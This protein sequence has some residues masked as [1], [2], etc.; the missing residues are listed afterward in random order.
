MRQRRPSRAI[1][2]DRDGTLMHNCHYCR[3]PE[4]VQ[5][6]PGV[7]AALG[8]LSGAG[9][10]LV[11]VTNQSGVAR[12]HVSERQ[13]ARVHERLRRILVAEGIPLEA[14]YYC[15]HHPEGSRSGYAEH[16]LCRKPEPGLLL[17]AAFEC[18]FAL[19]ASWFVGDIL[20]DVEAGNRAGCRTVL[21]DLGTEP[22]PETALQTPAYVARNLPHAARLILAADGRSRRKVEPL[23]LAALDRPCLTQGVLRPGDPSPIPTAQWVTQAALEGAQ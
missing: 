10:R 22:R 16:C 7:S 12:G 15:P 3:D 8:W 14:I 6:L 19:A 1:V 9:Y 23:P 13:L 20:A 4:Q 11:V 18:G 5:L 21:L 2:L 17:R